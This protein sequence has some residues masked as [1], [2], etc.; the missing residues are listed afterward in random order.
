MEINPSFDHTLSILQKSLDVEML[1][2][3]AISNNIANVATPNY[4]RHD[5]AFEKEFLRA[6]ASKEKATKDP[7]PPKMTNERHMPFNK[8]VDP[9]QVRPRVIT[10]YVSSQVNN[11]N[12]VDIEKES[13]YAA[14]VAERYSALSMFTSRYFSRLKS[15]IR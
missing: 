14:K 3:K 9:N 6:I 1:R 4:K 11:G 10:D 13:V 2:Q 8:I 15:V 12:N 7:F 5:V